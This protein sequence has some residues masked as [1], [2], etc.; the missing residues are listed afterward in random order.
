MPDDRASKLRMNHFEGCG[1]DPWHSLV[2]AAQMERQEANRI[3]VA[4]Y[5]GGLERVL[6]L[7]V[8]QM[9]AECR[10]QRRKSHPN[11]VQLLLESLDWQLSLT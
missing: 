7:M 11:T 9:R 5:D 2:K 6:S 10:V 4:L 1:H 3:M 8:R